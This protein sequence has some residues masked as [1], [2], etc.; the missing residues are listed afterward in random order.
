MANVNMRTIQEL[1]GHKTMKMTVRYSHLSE[2]YKE[3]A[4]NILGRRL[5]TTGW[6]KNGT[7]GILGNKEKAEKP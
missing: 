2:E 3:R 4:I 5:G 7:Q 6:H 1:M